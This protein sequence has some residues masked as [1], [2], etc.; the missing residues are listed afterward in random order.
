MLKA[1]RL[2]DCVVFLASH[3]NLTIGT[4]MLRQHLLTKRLFLEAC[5]F[6]ARADSVSAGFAISMLQDAAEMMVWAVVKDKSLSVKDQSG[7]VAQIDAITKA[8]HTLSFVPE[9]H[10][11]NKARVGFKH[12]GNLPA[13]AEVPKHR[14]AVE[15]FLR[16]TLQVYFNVRFDELTLVALVSD[17]EISD[18]LKSA[19]THAASESYDSAMIDLAK[20]RKTL[21]NRLSKYVPI[22]GRDVRDADKL[23]R[24]ARRD[25]APSVFAA[26]GRHLDD[27][28]ETTLVALLRLPLAE[29]QFLRDVL[30][31]VRQAV[32]GQWYIGRRRSGTTL[33]EY[34]RALTC[35]VNG[36][37][38]LEAH[39][40]N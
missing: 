38:E 16:T 37:V 31:Q 15:G 23:F 14:S 19:E 7:F 22:V 6:A 26:L 1:R 33:Q 25:R 39:L 17:V 8:G 34:E 29:Y 4:P 20:A 3:L 28:R 30:P 13:V 40:L 11:L 2:R 21:F 24:E 9:L 35:I 32:G 10:E 5:T 12:Y 36:C 27:L 18:Y